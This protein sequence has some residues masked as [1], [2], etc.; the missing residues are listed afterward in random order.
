MVYGLS[1]E[2]DSLLLPGDK[3]NA[4]EIHLAI[5]NAKA[6]IGERLEC[7]N[8]DGI[9]EH[10]DK[11]DADPGRHSA[12]QVGFVRASTYDD[13]LTS[14]LLEGSLHYI[15]EPAEE[16]GLFVVDDSGELTRVGSLSHS[17]LT[18]MEE[19]DC[20]SQYYL[21]DLSRSPTGDLTVEGNL[22]PTEIKQEEDEDALTE[23]HIAESWSEAH[24][25]ESITTRL[26]GW[27]DLDAF[28]TIT[29]QG[30][31]PL[32]LGGDFCFLPI[33]EGELTSYDI[34]MGEGKEILA[35]NSY[36]YVTRMIE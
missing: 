30:E 12:S 20:H 15:T 16:E 28:D 4:Y 27:A 18:D 3:C 24:G 36:I 35:S 25:A 17:N 14:G 33:T 7:T 22:F 13:R 1:E 5:Q 29:E 11:S 34:Y 31:G 26:I 19:D 32:T 6:Q 2:N 10:G 8:S 9:K 21:S 23:T